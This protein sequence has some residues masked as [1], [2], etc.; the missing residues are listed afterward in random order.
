MAN[1]WDNI[2]CLSL[3]LLS[4]LESLSFYDIILWRIVSR[5]LYLSINDTWLDWQY[6]KLSYFKLLLCIYTLIACFKFSFIFV[7]FPCMCFEEVQASS[8]GQFLFFV[9]RVRFF[10]CL[11]NDISSWNAYTVQTLWYNRTCMI[12][13]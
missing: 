6:L 2:L 3:N 5:Y 11:E 13:S 8:K 9:W 4:Y 12:S 7:S 1:N 10:V